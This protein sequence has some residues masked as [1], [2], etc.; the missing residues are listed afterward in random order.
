MVKS[1]DSCAHQKL[2]KCIRHHLSYPVILGYF[3]KL[4]FH[5]VFTVDIGLVAGEPSL[6]CVQFPFG[7]LFMCDRGGNMAAAVVQMSCL[8]R[9]MIAV[10]TMGIRPLIP[11]LVP[12]Q[13]RTFSVKKEPELEV[14]PY[15]SKY[16]EKIR[17]LRRCV[18]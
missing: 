12:L 7:T 11:G 2:V 5:Y 16:E 8:Y 18:C 10:R 15:Y 14:N 1:S 17:K 3:I 6:Y 9:G 13:F 4:N